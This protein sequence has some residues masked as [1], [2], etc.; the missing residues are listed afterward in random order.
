MNKEKQF[1]RVN[2]HTIV[3]KFINVKQVYNKIELN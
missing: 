2:Y 1:K 3:N